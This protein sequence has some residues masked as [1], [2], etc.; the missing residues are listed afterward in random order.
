MPASLEPLMALPSLPVG[1]VPAAVKVT[2][3]RPLRWA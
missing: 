3:V 1:T 2:N